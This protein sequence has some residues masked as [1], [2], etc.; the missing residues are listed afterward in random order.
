MNTISN[1]SP[2]S[3][4]SNFKSSETHPLVYVD[5]ISTLQLKYCLTHEYCDMTYQE[6][7]ALMDRCAEIKKL[8]KE[9]AYMKKEEVEAKAAAA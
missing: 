8:L 7:L 4:I 3:I 2:S 9:I 1:Q 5:L 6:Q